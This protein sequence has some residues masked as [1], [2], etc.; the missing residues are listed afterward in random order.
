MTISK[1]VE[2]AFDKLSLPFIIKSLFKLEQL[3]FINMKN[4]ND[5]KS[6]PSLTCNG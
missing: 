5:Q 6:V 1:Y 4:V 3:K 2:N